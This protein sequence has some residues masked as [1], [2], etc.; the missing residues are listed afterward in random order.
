MLHF[1]WLESR[2]V[3]LRKAVTL[4]PVHTSNYPEKN[5]L[6]MCSIC[7]RPLQIDELANT[8]NAGIV[9]VCILPN[10][11]ASHL[12]CSK[13]PTGNSQMASMFVCKKTTEE[14]PSSMQLHLESGAKPFDVRSKAVETGK[15]KVVAGCLS[16]PRHEKQAL[17]RMGMLQLLKSGQGLDGMMGALHMQ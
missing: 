5:A 6:A 11:H 4:T 12:A 14:F 7:S 3:A 17:S 8:D 13:L 1:R 15:R 9:S 10:G 16:A 2:H